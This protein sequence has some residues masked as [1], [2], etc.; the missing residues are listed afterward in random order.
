MA[1]V[2]SRSS[3]W[4]FAVLAAV[5]LAA[6]PA[7]TG[8]AVV[9]GIDFS[10]KFLKAVVV[11]AGSPFTI[12]TNPQSKRKT[13]A[14]V[15]FYRGERLFGYDADGIVTRRPKFTFASE[16]SMLGATMDS[17][18]VKSHN[19]LRYASRA[20]ATG[21]RSEPVLVLPDHPDARPEAGEVRTLP[22]AY[23][24]Q[25]LG[26]MRRQV[27]TLA[28]SPL[29]GAVVAVPS[30]WGHTERTAL[31]QAADIAG[32]NVLRVVDENVAAA[33]Q[34]GIDRLYENDTNVLVYNMGATATQ[35][36][37]FRF[38]T[39]K[40]RDGSVRGSAVAI[41]KGWDE[42]LGGDA[43]D[44]LLVEHAA[45]IFNAKYQKRLG[46]DVRTLARPM[47][48]LVKAIANVKQVLSANLEFPVSV[49][50]MATTEAGDIDFRTS[51]TRETLVGLAAGLIKRVAGPA[52]Q[53]CRA[54]GVDPVDVEVVE[55]IGGSIRVPAFQDAL[56]AAMR[57]ADRPETV[58]PTAKVPEGEPPLAIPALGVHLNG[59]EAVAFGAAFMAAN[60]SKSFRVRPVGMQDTVPF[61]ITASIKAAGADADAGADASVQRMAPYSRT[62]FTR[63][64][65]INSTSD[66]E[67]TLAY[68]QA[69]ADAVSPSLGPELG[70]FRIS[71]IEEAA[72]SDVAVKL[73]LVP[74]VSVRVSVSKHGTVSLVKGVARIRYEEEVPVATPTPKPVAA[75][76]DADADADAAD[77]TA[78]A[79]AE[80][81]TDE[82]DAKDAKE[83]AKHDAADDASDSTAGSDAADEPADEPADEASETGADDAP[84]AKEAESDDAAADADADGADAEAPKTRTRVRV[85]KFPLKIERVAPAAGVTP[86]SSE[87][88][89]RMA[90]EV[91]ELQRADDARIARE[92]AKNDLEAAVMSGRDLSEEA[93]E[94]FTTVT[95]EE[96]RQGLEA[97]LESIDEWLYGDGTDADI[98]G[99]QAKR[100]ELDDTVGP[101]RSRMSEL[102]ERPT[103][104]AKA[105]KAITRFT[106]TITGWAESKPW[107][108]TSP[109]PS[110][111]SARAFFL[112][113]A[114]RGV[115]P[116]ADSTVAA[117][118]TNPKPLA[119][120]RPAMVSWFQD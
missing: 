56:A 76:G 26:H 21:N 1:S 48:K 63:T 69:D 60:F 6:S 103:A 2:Q 95:S 23:A 57:R 50:S 37:L 96:Q 14:N 81:A 49:E 20:L 25:L 72:T 89:V 93:E 10:S 24:A 79:D 8:V 113:C 116:R 5:L 90:G 13:S 7:V 46:A 12:V 80:G 38:G 18:R 53:A 59:D 100:K 29:T 15:A 117:T 39:Y 108:R 11:Q 27:E 98:E 94:A 92:Q 84:P 119:A 110:R 107:V 17:D 47:A 43:L 86:L 115:P 101:I 41:G 31:L 87:D 42:T 40:S 102:T 68:E 112:S 67:V 36:T 32:L 88:I 109:C 74:N 64:V 85:A 55:I 77:A 120:R 118:G 9:A 30:F 34:F 19:A 54:A 62:G 33:T 83:D 52:L 61:A 51:I 35:A 91:A 97:I 3:T 58:D 106:K 73:G 44:R 4:R 16:H 114:L 70:T 66:V 28:G 75:E 71:G 45:D 111:R 78:D 65:T 99:V 105:T 82:A 22:E 104:A